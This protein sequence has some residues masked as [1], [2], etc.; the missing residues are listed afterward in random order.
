MRKAKGKGSV[1]KRGNNYHARWR[2]LGTDVYGIARD[3]WDE[4]ELDRLTKAPGQT[5]APAKKRQMP[6][7]QQWAI[8]CQEGSYGQRVADSTLN[9]NETLRLVHIEGSALGR[10]RL[11]KINRHAVQEFV[12]QKRRQ[13]YQVGSQEPK[14]YSAAY[15][16]RLFAFVARLFSEAV[17]QDLIPS[18]PAT[19]IQLPDVPER[20]NRTLAP[21]EAHLLL[22]PQTR[23]DALLLVSL[24][25]G[26]RRSE[27][28]RLQWSDI[29]GDLIRVPGS[30][31]VKSRA[32]V[33]MTPEV[34][35]AIFAQPK[36]SMFIF[37]ASTGQ[38]LGLRNI[39]RDV[40]KRMA[41]LGLPPETRLHDLRGTYG[42]LLIETGVDI[43]TTQD[44]MRHSDPRTTM[45]MYLRSRQETKAAAVEQLRLKIAPKV[46]KKKRGS[47]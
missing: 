23:T 29:D 26:M 1:V 17:H 5:S 34:K 8:M 18:S 9:T 7:F 41:Q 6:T 28:R 46:E 45:K 36:R 25:T 16:V 35:A 21:Q 12:D 10:M 13:T 11:D 27:L 19:R 38:P 32:L 2:I 31:S 43:K 30:K 44:L 20:E 15:I 24:Y 4:A 3:T 14:L 47:K 39:N 22:N 42:S 37:S 40:K 33:P